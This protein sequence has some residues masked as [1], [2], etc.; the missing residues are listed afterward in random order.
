MNSFLLISNSQSKITDYLTNFYKDHAISLFDQ[1]IISSE[2]T[3]G[4]EL[5][6]KMQSSLFLA[7]YKGNKKVIVIDHAETLTIEAQNALLK[8]LEEPPL[9]AF[10]F[11][12]SSSP[13]VFLPTILSRCQSIVLGQE[14]KTLTEEEKEE[15]NKQLGILQTG[16]VNEKLTLAEKIAGEKEEIK[17]WF[18][19]IQQ[20]ARENMLQ[21]T[22]P[23]LFAHILMSLQKA[24]KDYT[25]T[26][27]SPRLILEHY[28][29]ANIL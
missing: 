19:N 11:L 25:T 4:I 23:Q 5:I 24:Y 21:D 8:V 18:A 14:I 7:P 29:L 10:I 28:F 1:T 13:D 6:R 17:T 3:I 12:T 27:V 15:I 16:T 22:H 26:N 9:F 20:V 2:T